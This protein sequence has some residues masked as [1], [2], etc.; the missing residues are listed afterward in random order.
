MMN[1]KVFDG[2]RNIAVDVY[3]LISGKSDNFRRPMLFVPLAIALLLRIPLLIWP[4]VIY[5]D[6]TIYVSAAKKILEGKLAEI[7][8][9]P[10]YP[11]L[12]AASHFI[13]CDF[14]LAG[15]LV[16]I[17]FGIFLVIP[18]FCLGKEMYGARI[19]IIAAL[20]ATVQPYLFKYSGSVLTESTYYF[21]VAAMMA[22]AFKCNIS[23][24][25]YYAIL[26]GILTGFGYLVRPEAIGF[27]IVF[28]FWVFLVNPINGKRTLAQ[29][30]IIVFLVGFCF[31]AVASPYLV[32]LKSELGRWELSKKISMTVGIGEGEEATEV[33]P[34]EAFKKRQITIRS[35]LKNPVPF[36]KASVI[37]V[38][39]AL[40]KFQQSFGPLLFLLA[41]WGFTRRKG[42]FRPWKQNLFVLSFALFFYCFVFPMFKISPRYTSHMIPLALPWASYGFIAITEAIHF[43]GKVRK[44]SGRTICIILCLV[45]VGLLV[46]GTVQRK[47]EH[48]TIQREA[49]LWLKHNVP[50]GEKLMSR[51]VQE[52]FYADM[53][54]ILMPEND[55]DRMI[56][57]A[58]SGSV[59]YI[60]IDEKTKMHIPNFSQK[61]EQLGLI[62]IH[63]WTQ[64]R[65]TI[66]L[67]ER[68]AQ[69]PKSTETTTH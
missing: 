46:Q 18:V 6:S 69:V 33:L 58:H 60:V 38:F 9:A 44:L 31:I 64:G 63:S 11:M 37:G 32:M 21:L 53:E 14:V 22:A 28:C 34:G 61:T 15:T 56:N 5:N 1:G 17:I 54:L 8:I 66:L 47:R 3:L 7:T 30:T 13:A 48:R 43:R 25:F 45:M 24:K 55:F 20:L 52:A 10:L 4:E 40:Y 42:V 27:L 67:F 35:L 16:S 57:V 12:I 68:T 49:G 51:T 65:R 39:Q 41:V 62:L 26:F 29:R 23:G 2:I 59:R 19:G 50:R 36:V